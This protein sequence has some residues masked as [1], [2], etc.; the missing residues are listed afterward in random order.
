MRNLEEHRFSIPSNEIARQ[1]VFAIRKSVLEMKQKFPEVLGFTLFGSHSYGKATGESDTDGYLYIDPHISELAIS[2]S[3]RANIIRFT[4]EKSISE[5]YKSYL[6]DSMCLN[7]TSGNE[8]CSHITVYPI[9]ES[10]INMSLNNLNDYY[11]DL[12]NTL[13]NIVHMFHLGIADKDLRPFRILALQKISQIRLGKKYEQ[14][15]F[16][17]VLD[18]ETTKHKYKSRINIADC[19]KL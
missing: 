1:K 5:K 6:V 18:F 2:E 8:D 3:S 7:T 13:S 17:Q 11:F 16:E 14:I 15:L 4:L 19:Y 12:S 10:I 9:S